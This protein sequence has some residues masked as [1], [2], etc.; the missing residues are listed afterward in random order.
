MTN[1]TDSF[2]YRLTIRQRKTLSLLC[3]GLDPKVANMPVHLKTILKKS[4]DG[5]Q[6]AKDVANWM[7][8]IVDATAKYACMFKLQKAHYEAL[9]KYGQYALKMVIDYIK[10]NYPDIPVFL[11]CKRGDI[12]ATQE[13]YQI[14][15]FEKDGAEGMNFSPYMGKSCMKALI[16]ADY[17]RRAIVGLCYTSNPDAREV[18]DPL[19]ATGEP[20]WQFIAKRTLAW[21]E[22]L[23]IVEDAGL[24]MA[25]A[26]ENPKGSGNIHNDHLVQCR[27]IVGDKLWFLVPAVGTQGGAIAETIAG[28]FAGWGSMAI[29][30]GSEIIFASKGEDFAQAAEQKAKENYEKMVLAVQPLAKNCMN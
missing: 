23:K 2:R 8:K 3:V 7:I 29:N 16:N 18:Q 1:I 30:N 25:A 15:H 26:Y 6:L 28:G 14:A 12:D 19:L 13:M 22:E 17:P 27:N 20:Y 4:D 24:V 10:K 21:A 11:D 5:L 9:G